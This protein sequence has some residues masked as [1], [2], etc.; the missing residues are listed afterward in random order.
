[1]NRA[2]AIPLSWLSL[3]LIVLLPGC[4]PKTA[5]PQQP[6]FYTLE[7]RPEPLTAK[8]I[9]ETI[10]LLPF[11]AA[12]TCQ[13]RRIL[14]QQADNQRRPFHYHRWLTEP[15]AMVGFLLGRDLAAGNLFAGVLPAGAPA[16]H[17][18]TLGGT[19]VEFLE[20]ERQEPWRAV[21]EVEIYLLDGD[22]PARVLL[23]KRYRETEPMERH[24]P[25]ALAAAMSR[26]MQRLSAAVRRD[27]H[28]VLAARAAPTLVGITPPA[29]DVRT[30]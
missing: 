16:S 4:L 1:M 5:P 6:F 2:R 28:A 7:Y 27:L 30:G 24:H 20:D 19:V 26:A 10:R 17:T 12:P 25:A 18:C 9:E 3:C 23:Q 21:L 8:R 13:G 15:A 11:A 22:R 29:S 14:Y